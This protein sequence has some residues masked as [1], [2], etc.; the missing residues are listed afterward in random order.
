MNI[1]NI[2]I[3]AH[4]DHGK[5][6]LVDQ[7]LKQAGVWRTN[8]TVA[9]RVMD[10]MDQERERGITIQ[11]KNA[12]FFYNDTK[13]NI[14]DTPGHS[15]FGGE[16]ERILG[17]VDGCCLLVDA[18]EGPLP[19]TRFVLRK[20]LEQ[21]LKI[22]VVINKID[23]PDARVQEVENEIFDLFIDL[24]AQDKQ[25]E[26]ETVY[27]IAREGF[28]TTE[29]DKS[30][31]S[32]GGLK[33]DLR[34]LFDAILRVM[35]APKV[36]PNA[37]LAM[38]ISNLGHNDFT[39]RLA[40]GRVRQGTLKSNQN[41]QI[42]GAGGKTQNFRIQDLMAYDGLKQV[43]V[44]HVIAGDIAVV[45]GLEDMHIGDTITV[46]EAPHVLQRIEVDP[47]SVRMGFMVNTSPF[48]GREG[49]VLLSRTLHDRLFK[50]TQ[51]NVSVRFEGTDQPDV[52]MVY[53]RGELQLA[54]IIE[55]LRREGFELAVGKPTAVTKMED[56]VLMEPI[57]M[58]YIDCPEEHL[59]AVT[60]M[61]SR[62]RGKMVNM[63][64][65]GSG[66][67]RL[68]FEVPSR[69]LIGFR[70][71]FLTA[72]RGLGLLNN[73]FHGFGPHRG[74]I[75]ERMNGALVSDRDGETVTYGLFHLEPRGRMFIGAGIPVYEGMIVGE[76]S[77]DN[78]LWVNATKEKKLTNM[79]ASGTDELMQLKPPQDM[80]LER[81]LEWIRDD[82]IVEVTPKNIRIRKRKLKAP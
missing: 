82:E 20:A 18:S 31:D 50:E 74:E 14:V 33:G 4:V 22:L 63:V 59:G 16:V 81:C 19:Q 72:T 66:R 56:G 60:E 48:A 79:R 52:F 76:H 36:D 27:C 67:V 42:V 49:K 43:K 78:D 39:G 11:A 69:G 26:Y 57:E 61:I 41:V 23:R 21:D 8:E 58:T 12:S 51:K 37:P 35:P 34:P 32:H 13:V 7:L 15:D 2:A 54:V 77:R 3:I 38:L 25:M 29:I 10:S 47:P 80:Y 70:T 6:T 5:T 64:N 44:D 53:G 55:S 17:M 45:A 75:P 9:D 65:K 40:I 62:R 71:H 1:R 68:E 28:A 73:L 30:K 46:P 24:E